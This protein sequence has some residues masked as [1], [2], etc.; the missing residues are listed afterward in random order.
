MMEA[1]TS[2]MIDADVLLVVTDL[3]STPIPDDHIFQRI[4]QSRKPVIVVINKIDLANKVQTTDTKTTA[5]VEQAV[6]LWRKLLPQASAILP[7][8]TQ[9]GPDDVG[10]VALRRILCGGPDVPA[11]LRNLGRPIAGMFSE[12][13]MFLTDDQ[14]KALLPRS[15]PLYDP[16]TLTDRTERFVASELIR[17]ALFESLKKELPYCCQV[18]VTQ[19]KEPKEEEK[20]KEDN[21]N[22]PNT[23]KKKKKK[24]PV[25]RIAAS[26]I[27][28]RESQK[29]IVVGKQG[30]KI[31]QVGIAAREKLQDFLQSKVNTCTVLC[32]AVLCC[33]FVRAEKPCR[34]AC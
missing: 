34:S 28:E 30:D 3:F 14:A 24:T 1:V 18:Q 25:I 21:E 13:T 5:T 8:T 32:C 27:V 19:F 7:C 15:P 22:H 31:K 17:A 9:S 11:A 16:E 4:H 23:S 12:S 20:E 10:V 6:A 33:T 26:I 2:S 29:S